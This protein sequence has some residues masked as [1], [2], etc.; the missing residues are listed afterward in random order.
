MN[1]ISFEDV[2]KFIRVVEEAHE[3]D[4]EADYQGT[5]EYYQYNVS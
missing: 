1:T 3:P 5:R 2:A 4:V